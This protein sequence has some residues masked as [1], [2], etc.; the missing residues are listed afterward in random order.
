MEK[1]VFNTNVQTSILSLA[2]AKNESLPAGL[3]TKLQFQIR[4]L[5]YSSNVGETK[6][7]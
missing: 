7:K 6:R 5:S 3:V 1:K 4:F 2:S